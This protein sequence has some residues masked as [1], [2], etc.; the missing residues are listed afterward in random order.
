MTTDTNIPIEVVEVHI[1]ADGACSGNPGAGGYG[2]VILINGQRQELSG[3]FR[4]T[5]NNRMEILGA[6]VGLKA[7][8]GLNGLHGQKRKV[9]I[10]SDS[11]Y[12]V[13]MFNGGHAVKWR[14]DGWTRNKGKD[15]VKN[16]DLWNEL[17]TVSANHE[18]KMVWVKGHA[19]N[20]H[21]SRCD[22]LAVEA[23]MRKD[24]PSDEGYINPQIPDVPEMNDVQAA[25]SSQAL[26][27]QTLFDWLR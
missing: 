4:Y 26:Q 6:I 7:L 1:Y 25:Q 9:T 17:L 23:R 16:P 18:V 15:Q 14:K 10:Y 27:E 24:L 5:T 3:G 19:S 22:E 8:N 12:L 20:P 2:V 11:Q 13:D 21:N